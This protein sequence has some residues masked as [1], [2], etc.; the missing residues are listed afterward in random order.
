[1]LTSISGKGAAEELPDKIQLAAL[2]A[3]PQGT[4]KVV[5]DPVGFQESK[6]QVGWS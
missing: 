2:S 5:L 3:Q 1:M 4:K 6:K